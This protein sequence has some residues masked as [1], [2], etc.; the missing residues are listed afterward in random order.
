[1]VNIYY[2]TAILKPLSITSTENT[3]IVCLPVE[4]N[5]LGAEYPQAY[6]VAGTYQGHAYYT[7]KLKAME[8][9]L[10]AFQNSIPLTRLLITVLSWI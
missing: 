5:Q 8:Y 7:K 9:L 6:S 1:M 3:V 2:L 10:A 4:I